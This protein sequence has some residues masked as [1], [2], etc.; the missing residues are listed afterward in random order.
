MNG[1]DMYIIDLNN[2]I[3]ILINEINWLKQEIN[4]KSVTNTD[5]IY[6]NKLQIRFGILNKCL[7]HTNV[8]INKNIINLYF[9]DYV[10]NIQ[11]NDISGCI[12]LKC[13]DNIGNAE[14]IY[15]IITV[16]NDKIDCVYQ[17]NFSIKNNKINVIFSNRPVIPLRISF[18]AYINFNICIKTKC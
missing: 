18:N 15:G 11:F 6:E 9:S 5:I 4:K 2:K 8:I 16:H 7:L 1:Y 14:I 10:E 17:G 3:D 13:V 12:K